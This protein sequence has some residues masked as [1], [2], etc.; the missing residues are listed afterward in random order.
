[1]ADMPSVERNGT[2]QEAA[3]D[4]WFD[5]ASAEEAR[6]DRIHG[7]DEIIPSTLWIVRPLGAVILLLY[8][9]FPAGGGERSVG[10]ALQVGTVVA[11]LG[12]ALVLVRQ[13]NQ[14]F[15]SGSPGLRPAAME[16]TLHTLEV[17]LADE[18]A[19]SPLPRSEVG[20]PLQDDVTSN[21]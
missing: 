20:E 11:L 18:D 13:L 16:R 9:L 6:R 17:V 1:V 10:Q 4:T 21:R 7:S 5:H 8:M 19:R 15:N 14:P 12:A 3:Y 2:T